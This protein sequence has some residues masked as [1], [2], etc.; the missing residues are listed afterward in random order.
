MTTSN[1]SEILAKGIAI[2]TFL[3][4]L[5]YNVFR[6]IFDKV[7]FSGLDKTERTLFNYI[8]NNAKEN[9]ILAI[10]RVYDSESKKYKTRCI[11][12]LLNNSSGITISYPFNLFPESWIKFKQKYKL[13]FDRIG[14]D[15]TE[16]QT[17]LEHFLTFYKD[18]KI[19]N[20]SF[21]HL[22]NWRDKILAHNEPYDSSEL[23]IDFKEI[24]FLILIPKSLIEYASAFMDT[25]DSIVMFD[26]KSDSYFIDNLIGKYVG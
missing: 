25:G 9:A 12:E 23:N 4:D 24:E 16:P 3:A 20:S 15:L 21:Q 8:K 5:N 26:G 17:Y 1:F 14:V 22:K 10:S 13:I 6:K 2:D 7:N 18:F 19:S 11:D